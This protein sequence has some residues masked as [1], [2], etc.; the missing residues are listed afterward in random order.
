M[1][2]FRTPEERQRTWTCR[3]LITSPWRNWYDRK[4]PQLTLYRA[5]EYWMW[6]GLLWRWF[7]LRDDQGRQM[8]V[9]DRQTKQ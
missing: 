2:I 5:I 7:S 4:P 1:S 3:V 6:H 8:L 9:P